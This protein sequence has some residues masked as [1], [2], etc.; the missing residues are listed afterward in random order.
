MY[1]TNFT[2]YRVTNL[3]PAIILACQCYTQ[4]KFAVTVE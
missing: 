4:F 1:T 2:V 3:L